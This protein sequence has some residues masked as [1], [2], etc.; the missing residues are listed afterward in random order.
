MAAGDPSATRRGKL[1]LLTRE[2]FV[3]EIRGLGFAKPPVKADSTQPEGIEA[4][5]L[6]KLGHR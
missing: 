4:R 3:E 6:R 1:F 2:A 5:I